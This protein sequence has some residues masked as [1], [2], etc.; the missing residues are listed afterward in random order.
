MCC[1]DLYSSKAEQ[2]DAANFA[3]L[4]AHLQL[5][6][7]GF[8]STWTKSFVGPWDPSQGV[9]NPGAAFLY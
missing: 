2:K 4:S 5:Q 6:N 7:E 3:V 8:L 1:F 9:H